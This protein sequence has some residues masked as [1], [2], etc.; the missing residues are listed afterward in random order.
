MRAA[1]KS[2]FISETVYHCSSNSMLTFYSTNKP[3]H[4]FIPCFSNS[5]PT[6]GHTRLHWPLR[7]HDNDPG[8]CLPRSDRSST[9]GELV[10]S[11]ALLLQSPAALVRAGLQERREE[12]PQRT[13]TVS[14]KRPK[15][16]KRVSRNG[17]FYLLVFRTA[18]SCLFPVVL[19]DRSATEGQQ[20]E[21]VLM[22]CGISNERR[23]GLLYLT[24]LW[25][26]CQ[27]VK[28][29]LKSVYSARGR[30]GLKRTSVTMIRGGSDPWPT[31]EQVL[32]NQPWKPTHDNNPVAQPYLRAQKA[33]SRVL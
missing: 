1:L 14:I 6:T 23:N 7:R 24:E 15:A 22:G 19:I 10:P 18:L 16:L 30:V 17:S 33:G 20:R 2:T 13:I 11:A 21:R 31:G 26:T 3:W 27:D 8:P 12:D 32:P 28:I 29:S 4:E 9:H 25:R 5:L